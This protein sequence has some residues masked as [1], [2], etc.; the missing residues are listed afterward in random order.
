VL[1]GGD[2]ILDVLLLYTS[3]LAE[4]FSVSDV[5]TRAELRIQ[6]LDEAFA[7]SLIPARARLVHVAEVSEDETGFQDAAVLSLLQLPDDGR[8]DE[9]PVLRDAYAAD[10]VQLWMTSR[11]RGCVDGN[12]ELVDG[13]GGPVYSVLRY[14]RTGSFYAPLHELGHSMGCDHDRAN[15]LGNHLSRYNYGYRFYGDSG[16]EYRDIMAYPPGV[17]LRL[18][19]NPDLLHDGKPA[20]V[21]HPD[22]NGQSADCARAIR[23]NVPQL[24]ALREAPAL[25]PGSLLVLREYLEHS[26]Q[27]LS[28]FGGPPELLF[29]HPFWS[30][31]P[32]RIAASDDGATLYVLGIN[33]GQ[34]HSLG[35]V[36]RATGAATVL[37]PWLPF[38]VGGLEMGPDGFL[39][40]AATGGDCTT[41]PGG[42]LKIDPASGF[43]VDYWLGG[44][45]CRPADVTFAP[46]GDLLV[47][48]P[49]HPQGCSNL[50][51]VVRVRRQDGI[52]SVVA[53]DPLLNSPHAMALA[54][55]GQL[56][57]L[58]RRPTGHGRLVRL[59]LETG[60][61]THLVDLF[62]EYYGGLEITADGDAWI[63]SSA[64]LRRL[65]APSGTLSLV[66]PDATLGML[67]VAQVTPRL[68]ACSDR[69]DQDG[70]GAL[71]FPDDPGCRSAADTTE[72]V[73]CSDG[74]DGDGDGLVDYPADPGCTSADD[75]DERTLLA[76]DNG[77]DDDRDGFADHLSDP[78]CAGPFDDS[79]R[80]SA[81][82]CDD[83]LDNDQDLRKDH[84][85]DTGCTAPD[86]PSEQEASQPCDDGLDNDQD[87]LID[88]KGIGS[89]D[90]GCTAPDDPSERGTAV[91]DNGLDDDG[92]GLV[93]QG[94][95]GCVDVWDSSEDYDCRDG[96]DNDFDQA[97]D[98]PADPGCK[99]ALG[100]KEN[101]R[102]NNWIDDDDDGK[103][104]HDGG[105]FGF[106]PDPQ[107]AD[108][109]YRDNEA[110]GLGWE[111]GPLLAALR[112]ARARKRRVTG[113]EPRER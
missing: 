40:D 98:Y 54:P 9:A 104:D 58:T 89:R 102:C 31:A 29:E 66:A 34:G 88:Y 35:R 72:I 93:D 28:R 113:S 111:V 19:S 112:F 14:S 62:E 74:I 67:A 4:S 24:E 3:K 39:Y 73:D 56:V 94:D 12:C 57:V 68:P 100:R 48:E 37:T 23:E 60:T 64:G 41:S 10:L 105:I 78:G 69:L 70:D 49:C 20:G 61:L 18:Y 45:L 46:N 51:S 32:M 38:E 2:A 90:P 109:P 55:D 92:D 59:D 53:S 77:Q 42:V 63:A 8:M 26:I 1:A 97:I 33:P 7:N 81:L 22:P 71:G 21:P 83:D 80:S 84:P 103:V 85:A 44:A 106:P 75:G 50:G 91:C 86:D 110:C 17:P 13:L 108:A 65:H 5:R 79:E 96:I 52:Q 11:V 95:D 36:D 25:V 82:P 6:E 76:C 15:A 99:N 30:I 101:P 107:C 27:A 43:V 16:L 47:A 87:G